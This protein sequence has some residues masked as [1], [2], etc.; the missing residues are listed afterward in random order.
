VK[1][2]TDREPN[3]PINLDVYTEVSSRDLA[4]YLSKIK[5]GETYI[6]LGYRTLQPGT[7]IELVALPNRFEDLAVVVFKEAPDVVHRVL[8]EILV[9][10]IFGL[11][12]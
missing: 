2:N 12:F 7:E 5:V 1:Q 8:P 11:R 3:Q 9:R 4:H 10:A 6:L